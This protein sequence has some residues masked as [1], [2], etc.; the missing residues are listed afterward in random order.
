MASIRRKHDS[1][2]LVK[3]R[4]G[5]PTPRSCPTSASHGIGVR[6]PGAPFYASHGIHVQ[7]VLTDNGSCLH[8]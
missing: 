8:N 1:A 7:R 4:D 5:W 2:F 6:D 3:W